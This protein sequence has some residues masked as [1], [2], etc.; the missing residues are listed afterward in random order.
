M[1]GTFYTPEALLRALEPQEVQPCAGTGGFLCELSNP[2]FARSDLLPCAVDL[3]GIT[4][5]AQEVTA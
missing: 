3:T 4:T 2:P 1:T 5:W